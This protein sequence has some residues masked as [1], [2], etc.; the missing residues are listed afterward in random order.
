V[1]K[2]PNNLVFNGTASL[3][4]T[5]VS[6]VDSIGVSHKILTDTSGSLIVNTGTS[7]INIRALSA[8]TDSVT[9]FGTVTVTA[10]NLDIRDLSADT[11]SVA[12]IG[13]V[14]VTAENLDIRD[15]S[16][17][18]DSVTV[19]GTVTVTAVNLDI[20]DLSATTDSVTV[21]GT[22]TVTAE[23]LDIRDLSADTDSVAV[24]GT[25]S[26]TAENLDIRNLS[27]VTDS[28]QL[29]SREFTESFASFVN[30]T[31]S[32]GVVMEDTS[33]Q[34]M[35]TYYVNNTGSNTMTAVLQISPVSTS[36]FFVNDGDGPVAIGPGN[37]AVLV[38]AKYLHY[39]R[40]FYDTAGAQCSFSVYFNSQV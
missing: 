33:Q 40:L 28:I 29:S 37:K 23:N 7:T 35:Y 26:I 22:V 1:R 25:V 2:L 18:T 9:V 17:T 14:T 21:F 8:D 38:N 20:R 5:L 27:G 12:V 36:S 32:A 19:F 39:T 16:A 10:V 11:D 6:G 15:L 34:S 3:L 4:N 30:V 13:T 31:D 24:I